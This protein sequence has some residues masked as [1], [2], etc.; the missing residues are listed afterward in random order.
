M[1]KSREPIDLFRERNIRKGAR[2]IPPELANLTREELQEY[3]LGTIREHVFNGFENSPEVAGVTLRREIAGRYWDITLERLAYATTDD[4]EK[5][6]RVRHDEQVG[7]RT[8]SLLYSWE[9]Q[10]T[11]D[12]DFGCVSSDDWH[13]AS[14]VFGTPEEA[15]ADA[16]AQVAA[17]VAEGE[18][19]GEK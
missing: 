12:D 7:D 1:G 8:I 13:L 4:P 2:G 14:E 6:K 16:R 19:E 10:P 15:Y 11:D 17:A 3:M 18:R 9:A 5:V